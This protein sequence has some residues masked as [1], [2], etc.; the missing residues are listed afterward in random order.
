M[1]LETKNILERSKP[2]QSGCW[3]YQKST[4]KSGYG[5]WKIDGKTRLAHRVAYAI[6]KG[7]IPDGMCI[8]HACDNRACV[9]PSHLF[10]GTHEDNSQDMVR[11]KRHGNKG[12]ERATA[13][14][15]LSWNDVEE[16]RN[17]ALATAELAR[18][19]GISHDH[20]TRVKRGARWGAARTPLNSQEYAA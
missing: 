19:F 7:D 9:N 12:A 18:I 14:R 1:T 5:R 10:I 4:L 17:S 6:A 20:V 2:D 16:I 13:P 8:C 3:I 15:K 11:K